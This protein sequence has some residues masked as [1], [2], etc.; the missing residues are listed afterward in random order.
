M[1]F[2]KHAYL[3]ITEKKDQWLKWV[4]LMCIQRRNWFGHEIRTSTQK[5]IRYTLNNI[6][7]N[8][9]KIGVNLVLKPRKKGC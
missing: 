6:I 4:T 8:Y 9:R 7:N 1:L 3:T 2:S 5:Y